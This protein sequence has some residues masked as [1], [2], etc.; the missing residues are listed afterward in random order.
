MPAK[1]DNLTTRLVIRVNDRTTQVARLSVSEGRRINRLLTDLEAKLSAE[2]QMVDPAGAQRTTFQQQRTETLLK[3]TRGII[4][5]SF[6]TI[7]DTSEDNLAGLAKMEQQWF[8]K[9][10]EAEIGVDVNASI[11]SAQSLRA[12]A[13][14][15]LING[16]PSA[17]WW[18]RQSQSLQNSFSDVI[19]QGMLRG[20]TTDEL[21]RR[22]RGTKA[23]GFSDGIMQASRAQAE[24]LVRTS[25]QT[26]A[27]EARAKTYEENSDIITGIQWVATFDK[28][29]C[30]RC[31]ALNG[32]VW[33]FPDYEPKG[34]DTEYPGGTLH[35]N[36]R[37]TQVAVF[38]SWD[39]LSED[40]AVTTKA[41][42]KS[43]IQA[44]FEKNLREQGL[45]EDEI[46]KQV[47]EGRASMDGQISRDIGFEEWLGGK[48]KSVQDQ[49]LGKGRAELWRAG[50][51]SFADMIDQRG[52]GLTLAQLMDSL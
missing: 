22:V 6:Q 7:A 14:D 15:T 43:N 25:V 12:I 8:L 49:M 19:R 30:P 35:W 26:V 40:R 47:F 21:V 13:S 4:G 38:K 31:A 48:S 37:C 10:A 20:Q 11:L 28:R 52:R 50:K 51:I 1:P 46:A 32:L 34:H 5:D 3:S 16:A 42:G 9:T 41:G 18:E 33:T 36:C 29:T 17:D 2:V 23:N 44:I 24:A 27:N 39:D 45:S